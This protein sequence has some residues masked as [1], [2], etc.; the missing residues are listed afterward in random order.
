MPDFHPKY[1]TNQQIQ[2]YKN[3]GFLLLKAEDFFSNQEVENLINYS[4][5]LDNW[6]ETPGKWMKYFEKSLID[7]S[8]ILQ[9]IENFFEYHS[10]FNE[11]FNG[12]KFLDL[13]TDLLEGEKPCLFKEKINFKYPGGGGFKPHQDAQA[14]WGVY[15]HTFHVSV[16]V[17]IDEATKENGYLELVRGKHKDGLLGPEWA[18]I[19]ES[20]AQSLKWEGLPTKTGDIIIFDSF[21]PHK[22]GPNLSSTP[23]RVLYSTYNKLSEGDFRKQYYAD[24]RKG[25]PPDIERDPSKVYEYKI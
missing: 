6:P 5:E 2:N 13:L 9:R 17:T 23:R 8:R 12:Q 19:P 16:L 15:G 3:D 18:E 21:V 1:L 22:S 14:G 7:E 20:V 11:M 25:Y 10:G 4:N 24:K